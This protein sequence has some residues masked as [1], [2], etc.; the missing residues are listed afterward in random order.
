MSVSVNSSRE[1]L[2]N[3]SVMGTRDQKLRVTGVVL[4]GL[5]KVAEYKMVFE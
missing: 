1:I 3:K 4:A 5:C 2:V